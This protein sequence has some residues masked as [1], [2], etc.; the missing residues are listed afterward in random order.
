MKKSASLLTFVLMLPVLLVLGQ[1]VAAQESAAS[2]VRDDSLR[3]LQE[4][5]RQDA[6]K[7]S[8]VT[9]QHKAGKYSTTQKVESVDFDGCFIK[10]NFISTGGG[11][12]RASYATNLSDLDPANIQI[13]H[14]REH[15]PPLYFVLLNTREMKR[16]VRFTSR[17]EALNQDFY[18]NYLGLFF[19]DKEIADEVAE[20]FG[21][22]IKLCS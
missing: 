7:H 15:Q 16:S 3:E 4:R 10:I 20:A 13:L 14:F 9:R 5:I 2:Q 11:L 19:T 8:I 22:A 1:R 6:L 21:R 12:F 18:M 17:S